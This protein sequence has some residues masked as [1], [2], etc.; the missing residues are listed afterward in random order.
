MK[1]KVVSMTDNAAILEGYTVE[2]V[3][4]ASCYCM[5][6]LVKPDTDYDSTFRAWDMDAQ[7]FV[8]LNGWL[9]SI[10]PAEGE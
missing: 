5:N 3:A 1:R 2:V 4:D 8:T 9:W 10:E 6:L 7:E